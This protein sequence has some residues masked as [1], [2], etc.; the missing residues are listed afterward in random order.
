MSH[1]TIDRN[2]QA[3]AD[4]AALFKSNA[5]LQTQ[6]GWYEKLFS[7]SGWPVIGELVALPATSPQPE[8]TEL[9]VVPPGM[10]VDW[11]VREM[12]HVMDI[13]L[14]NFTLPNTG[15]LHARTAKTRSY[16][17][18]LRRRVEADVENTSL[19]ARQV[20][21]HEILGMTLT[22]RLLY[23]WSRYCIVRQH[24]DYDSYTLC[25]GTQTTDGRVPAV[26]WDADRDQLLIELFDIDYQALG[27]RARE[28]VVL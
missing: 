10:A 13:D 2:Q 22:E 26:C 27:V 12:R 20:W 5:S 3:C 18:L 4:R 6:Y 7:S 24:L 1:Q 15:W 11:L 8:F 25:T 21:E 19:S 17:V 23:E 9:V 14:V 28:V 16:A